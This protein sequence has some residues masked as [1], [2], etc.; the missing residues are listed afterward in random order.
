MA[1]CNTCR[2]WRRLDTA[3]IEVGY[4]HRYPP[5]VIHD[6]GDGERDTMPQTGP[7]MYCGEHAPR[8]N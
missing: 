8:L 5:Q 7:E 1:S 6:E 2:H 3:E 4:C